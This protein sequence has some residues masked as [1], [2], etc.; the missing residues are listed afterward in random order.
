MHCYCVNEHGTPL[1][2]IE[3]EIPQPQGTEVLIKVQAAG[4]CHTDLHLWDGSYDLGGGKRLALADRGVKPPIILS[5]EIAGEVVAVGDQVD[6]IQLG[7]QAVVHPWIGC[8]ECRYCQIDEENL[9]IKPQ[10]LGIVKPGGFAEYIIVPHTRYLVDIQGIDPAEAAPLACAGLSTFSAL[11]KFG[12]HTATESVVI[13]GAGGLGLM[14]LELLKIQNAK[15][16]IMVD[17]DAQKLDAAAEL[18]ALHCINSTAPDAVQQIQEFTQGGARLILD[19]VGN[20]SSLNF[21]LNSAARGAHIVVCGLM[22]GE[23]NL[24]IPTIPMR[25]LTIQG[26]YV[27]TVQELRALVELIAQT[28]MPHIPIQKRSINEVNQAFVDLQQGKVI[29]RLVLTH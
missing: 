20:S 18:G 10:Q 11:Q 13:I 3:R 28:R 26:S 9:C 25:P 15:A 24:S 1:E 29:G 7:M 2:R 16:P 27:G 23:V 17:I 8:G 12:Q 21:A 19:L 14:A 22:G 4:L 6:D 5:H